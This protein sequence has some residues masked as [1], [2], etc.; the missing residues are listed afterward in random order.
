MLFSLYN[1]FTA[2]I[3]SYPSISTVYKNEFRRYVFLFLFSWLNYY[4]LVMQLQFYLAVPRVLFSVGATRFDY[5]F[6][7]V[8]FG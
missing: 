3:S 6:Y 5:P 2:F 1:I 7:Y 8:W 4:R